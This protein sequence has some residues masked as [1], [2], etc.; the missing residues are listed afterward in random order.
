MNAFIDWS[1]PDTS[2]RSPLGSSKTAN[3]GSLDRCDN[4]KRSRQNSVIWSKRL[5]RVPSQT[6]PLISI[7]SLL[8]YGDLSTC[9]TGYLVRRD[10]GDFH[11][12]GIIPEAGKPQVFYAA[13]QNSEFNPTC[14]KI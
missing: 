14:L 5:V 6:I 2:N 9:S 13:C 10:K 12:S 4:P 11:C 8:Y 3:P 1:A 7:C